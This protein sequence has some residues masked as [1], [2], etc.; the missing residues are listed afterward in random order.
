[1]FFNLT[2][3]SKTGH[4][5]TPLSTIHLKRRCSGKWYGTHFWRFEQSEKLSEIKPP[6]AK[7]PFL[8]FTF[9]CNI[10]GKLLCL[11]ICSDILPTAIICRETKKKFSAGG[12]GFRFFWQP[13]NTNHTAF[14]LFWIPKR[15]AISTDNGGFQLEFVSISL[16][17]NSVLSLVEITAFRLENKSC[18]GFFLNKFSTNEGTQIYNRSC[19][20]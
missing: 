4:Q 6:L 16:V 15:Q 9:K 20:L 2:Q 19:D 12:C 1:M 18:K 10:I 7:L 5:I 14:I 13:A 8:F 11:L 3:I 17:I